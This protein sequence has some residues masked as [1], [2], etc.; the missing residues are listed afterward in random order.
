MELTKED[1]A[2]LLWALGFLLSSSDT[3]DEAHQ[4]YIK[5]NHDRVLPKIGNMH[6]EINGD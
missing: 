5:E 1:T 4:K 2:F 6:E 3:M